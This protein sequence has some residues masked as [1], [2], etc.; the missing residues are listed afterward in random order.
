MPVGD[1]VRR[2]NISE[3]MEYAH[4]SYR[5]EIDIIF[6]YKLVYE[7]V[8]IIP[9]LLPFILALSLRSKI[10]LSERYGCP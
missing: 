1:D 4:F 5:I 2:L 3:C 6:S 8:V 9:P 7:S 10:C